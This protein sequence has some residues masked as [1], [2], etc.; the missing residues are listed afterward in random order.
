MVHIGAA[1]VGVLRHVLLIELHRVGLGTAEHLFLFFHR[2]GVE[3][4]EFM[5]PFLRD[6]PAATRPGLPFRNHRG[7]QSLVT[8][9]V[10]NAID[11]AGQIA[12]IV[13]NETLNL[14]LQSQYLTQPPR[15]HQG[16]VEQVTGIFRLYPDQQIPLRG[17]R[18]AFQGKRRKAE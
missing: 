9:G 11:E 6:H 15:R 17:G 3:A 1:Y 16:G 18:L 4:F 5:H 14:Q 13:V 2:Q 10:A 7:G 12:H 8:G